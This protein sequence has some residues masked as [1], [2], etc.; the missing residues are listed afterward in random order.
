[1]FL[2]EPNTSEA[3][4]YLEQEQAAAGY[5]M[6][7]ERA[8]AW[9]PD[10]A[11][12]FGA[13]RQQLTDHSSLSA[14]EIALLVCATARALGDSYCSLAWGTRFAKLAAPETAADILMDID[15]ASLSPR[16]RSLRA[17]AQLVVSDPNGTTQ[18]Q[19]DDLR[20][21]GLSDREIFEA[22]TYVALRLAFS[23]VNDALGAQ[24]DR[25]LAEAAPAAVQAA[26]SYGRQSSAR[27]A[28]G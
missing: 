4:S 1:M 21:A 13:L 26:V 18:L 6:N 17:W 14:R 27:G 19:V 16:E 12:S 25:Q 24:P 8:W 11:L 28:G 23:T 2:R 22:T 5:V 7:L 3:L 15:S 9:R 20:R 10:I